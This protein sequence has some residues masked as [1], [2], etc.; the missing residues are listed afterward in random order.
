MRVV[1]WNVNG[2]RSAEGKGFSRWLAGSEATI[3]GLQEV[4]ARHEQVPET[5]RT[6][7]GWH[8]HVASAVRPGYSGVALLSRTP[9]KAVDTA[10]GEPRFDDEGRLQLARFGRLLVANVTPQQQRKRRQLRIP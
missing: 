3:V 7:P 10:L 5:V 4:R 9:P 1:S 8:V 6:A 2:I